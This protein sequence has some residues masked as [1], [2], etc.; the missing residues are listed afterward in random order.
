MQRRWTG[1]GTARLVVVFGAAAASLLSLTTTPVAAAQSPQ[2]AFYTWQAPGDASTAGQRVIAL[3]FDDGPGPYTPQVLSVL[4][5][6]HVPATFFEIGEN[7][8]DYPQYTQMVAAAGY[9]VENHTWSHPDLATLSAGQIGSQIEQTQNEIRSLTGDVPTCLRPPYDDWNSTV[10]DQIASQRLTAMSYSIDPRDWSMP[11]VAAIVSGVVDA[12]FPGAVVD[13]HDG[14]G[15]RSET[16]AALPAIISD[17]ESR[18]YTFVAIC[19]QMGSAPSVVL[20][21][22]GSPSVFAQGIGGSLWNYWYANGAWDSYEVAPSGVAS[23]PVAVLQPDG[24]PSVFFE[25]N[26]ESLWNYWYGSGVWYSHE[27]VAGGVTSTPAVVLQQNGAPSVFVQSTGNGLLN[28][29]Y[30]PSPGIWGSATVAGAGSDDSPPAVVVQVSAGDAPSVFIEGPGNSLLNYWYVPAQGIFG[31]ATVAASGSAY[32]APAV[33]SQPD[34]APSV[35]VEGPASTLWNYW[36]TSG[37][38]ASSGVG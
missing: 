17:L 4:E 13:M 11:G 6:Y 2:P 30:I 22:D 7:I 19:G 20:Q 29:W 5:Q 27:I 10:L 36:Y 37:T 8:V 3:T 33:V 12:A 25:G 14:G 1:I 24:S 34:G 23:P 16:V 38:W 21:P 35:F 18:G 32:S 9:P 15:N 31:A 26:G 28:F